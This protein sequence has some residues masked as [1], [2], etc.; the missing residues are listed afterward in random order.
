MK[1]QDIITEQGM[2]D[3]PG[4]F[5][6][7]DQSKRDG[8]YWGI[9]I[10]TIDPTVGGLMWNKTSAIPNSYEI[11]RVIKFDEEILTEELNEIYMEYFVNDQGEEPGKEIF[12][13]LYK[14]FMKQIRADR[15]EH[16]VIWSEDAIDRFGVLYDHEPK[17]VGKPIG[18]KD[19]PGMR[20]EVRQQQAA[21]R[22]NKMN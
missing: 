3:R 10:D 2:L 12:L 18:M 11:E 16:M 4:V 19:S 21:A 20:K 6:P 17:R 22:R 8:I 1:L 5:K 15:P 14:E 13:P 7:K 9:Y